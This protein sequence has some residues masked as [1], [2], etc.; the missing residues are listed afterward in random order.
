[1]GFLGPAIVSS[2]PMRFSVT[3]ASFLLFETTVGASFASMAM[4][5]SQS[6]PQELQGTIMNIFRVPLNAIVCM[7]AHISSGDGSGKDG[8]PSHPQI[9]AICSLLMLGSVI[10][11]FYAG[12]G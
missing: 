3:L 7:G 10:C 5:R 6:I 8:W 9:F 4:L 12:H 1:M 11:Q 2:G